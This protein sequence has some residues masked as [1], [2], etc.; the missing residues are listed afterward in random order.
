MAGARDGVT[1]SI[2]V[3]PSR[4]G[5]VRRPAGGRPQAWSSIRGSAGAL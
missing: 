5:T 4:P 3:Q 1:S 2:G